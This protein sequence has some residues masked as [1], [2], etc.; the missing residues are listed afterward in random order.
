MLGRGGAA[1][2]LHAFN[3]LVHAL[4][5][6]L[7]DALGG[8]PPVMYASGAYRLNV[9]AGVCVDIGQFE[10]LAGHATRQ[11][12]AGDADAAMSSWRTAVAMYRGDVCAVHDVRG[13]VER[14]RLRALHLSLLAS[15][16]DRCFDDGDYKTALEHAL[17]LLSHD[18]CRE[19][20]HR[21]VMRC[22]V[23]L[24]ERAQ[25]LRQYRTCLEILRTEFSACPETATEALFERVRLSPESV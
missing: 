21:V 8:A 10:A 18:P 25:A 2:S 23:R 4:R 22:H 11:L 3:S 20:A 9:D 15:M 7:G 1:P 17:R 12:R 24:G 5:P 14:E 6:L 16:A 19:D 13:V